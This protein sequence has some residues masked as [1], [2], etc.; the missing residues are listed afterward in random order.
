MAAKGAATATVGVTVPA[1][2]KGT[3]CNSQNAVELGYWI[4]EWPDP[5][6]FLKNDPVEPLGV[7]VGEDILVEGNSLLNP[8][9]NS[10]LKSENEDEVASVPIEDFTG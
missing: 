2:D 9:I 4:L 10:S 6:C 7:P 3:N 8:E 1:G 5:F